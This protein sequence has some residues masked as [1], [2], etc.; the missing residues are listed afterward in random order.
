MKIIIAGAGSVGF[1]LAELMSKENQDITLI[2]LDEEVLAYASTHLDLLTIKGDAASTQILEQ[3]KVSSSNLFIA[4]TTSEKTN[5]LLAILAK[6]YGAQ[7]TIARINNSEYLALDQKERF[8]KL[9]VDVLISPNQLA[10][11]EMLRLLERAS[12][13]DLFEFQ[14]GKLSIVGFTLDITCPLI[15]KSLSYIDEITGNFKFKG[16]ALLREQKT[17]IPRGNTILKKGD[18]LYVAT[19]KDNLDEVIKFVG[20]QLKPIKNVMILGGTLLAI[21]TAKLIEEQYRVSIV[22]KDKQQ[23][24]KCLHHLQNSLIIKADAG[25]I[26]ALKEEGLEQMDAFIALTPNSETNIITSLTAEQLGVYKTIALVDNINYTHISQ[27]I[28]IDTIINKKLIAANNISRF[29]R[30]GKIETIASLH[31]VD[32]EIIEFVVHKSNRLL[33]HPIRDLNF[34]KESIIAG[35]IRGKESHLPDGGFYFKLD[36]KVIVLALPEAIPQMEKIFK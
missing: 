29:V 16:I 33:D 20:K 6:Q 8:N 12:L 15:N 4:V 36:D 21:K 7:K 28:G 22:I 11:Q 27:N 3:A 17:I 1:H 30:E 32:A 5:I 10:A 35:V 34:P 23:E 26:E 9:G 19:Q 24:E 13:T 14:N 31:G 2:D 18:H 25:N